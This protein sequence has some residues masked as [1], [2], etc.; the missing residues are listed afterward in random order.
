[1]TR[2]NWKLAVIE[3]INKWADGMIHLAN[4]QLLLEGQ[5]VPFPTQSAWSVSNWSS[6]PA[7][8]I[9]AP[10]TRDTPLPSKRLMQEAAK[11]GQSQ[12]KERMASLCA[13]RRMSWTASNSIVSA[14]RILQHCQNETEAWG[15]WHVLTPL[16]KQLARVCNIHKPTVYKTYN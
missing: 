10:E 15:H 2:I 9:T 4:I 12:I 3:S 13:P 16:I 7:I 11:R 14:R 8:F 1:M 5:T 6:Y